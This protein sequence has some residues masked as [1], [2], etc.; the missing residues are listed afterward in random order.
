MPKTPWNDDYAAGDLPWDIGQPDPRL[1]EFV[2]SGAVVP[3]RALDVGC[4]TGTDAVWLAERG[5]DVLGVD[6]A[7]LAVEQARS[8][9]GASKLRCRFATFDFLADALME[10]PFDF[11]FDR[12]CFHGFEKVEERSRFAGRVAASLTTGGLWLSL[13]RSTEG[14]A[15]DLETPGRSACDVVCAIESGLEILELRSI[16]SQ[17]ES[18]R[19]WFC[20][21]RKR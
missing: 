12:G 14:P 5:F 18:A 7:P 2:E 1:V 9:L 13:I 6:I 20:L 10:P 4:G 15:R 16:P 3:G 8:K 11:V 17:I 21:S 19:A